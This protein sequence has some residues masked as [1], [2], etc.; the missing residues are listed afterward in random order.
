M[1]F[2]IIE[3]PDH[4]KFITE[5]VALYAVCSALLAGASYIFNS[6]QFFGLALSAVFGLIVLM[7][8]L[9]VWG[10]NI[11]KAQSYIENHFAIKGSVMF[12]CFGFVYTALILAITYSVIF[13]VFGVV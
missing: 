4:S 13:K 1:K 9:F 3:S 2:Q 12:S 10:S 8:C 6:A 5:Q 7:A 11:N